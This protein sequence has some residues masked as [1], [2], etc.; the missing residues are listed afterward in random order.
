MIS[1]IKQV[2]KYR[3]YDETKVYRLYDEMEVH[4]GNL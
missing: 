1:I 2:N 4:L 3:L